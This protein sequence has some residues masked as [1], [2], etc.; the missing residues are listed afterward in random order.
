MIMLNQLKIKAVHGATPFTVK[1]L[2][3]LQPHSILQYL[4]TYTC[5]M[6]AQEF[7]SIRPTRNPIPLISN[8]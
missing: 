6:I 7:A 3:T 4:I 5:A 2:E 1:L 8:A